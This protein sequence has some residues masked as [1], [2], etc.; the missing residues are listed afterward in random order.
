MSDLVGNL[1]EKYFIWFVDAPVIDR[2]L[3]AVAAYF[4]L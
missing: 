4:A 1:E 2:Q 3:A